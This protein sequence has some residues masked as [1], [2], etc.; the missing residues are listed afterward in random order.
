MKYKLAI[1]Y[2]IYPGI[3]KVPAIFS[4]NKLRM[5][6]LA[7]RSFVRA[8]DGID[9]KIWVLLDNCDDTYNQLFKKYLSGMNYELINLPPSGNAGTFGMQMNILLHQDFSEY[10]FFAED[11]YFYLDNSLLPSLEILEK[12]FADFVT[13]YNHPE[14]ESSNLHDYRV[15]IFDVDGRKWRTAASTTMT[16]MTTR[17][18]LEGSWDKFL[19]YTKLNYDASMW[20]AITKFNIRNPIKIVKDSIKSIEQLKIYL[21]CFYFFPFAYLGRK[22]KLASPL[23]SLATHLDNNGL[24]KEVNW[25]AEFEKFQ[26]GL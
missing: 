9:A 6:E 25:Q 10:I 8:L 15:E 22:Q 4:D 26:N 11:D 19:S 21:K 17:K 16:F 7:L 3:S 24:P 2:R 5:S 23:Q 1:C 14:L 13:P 20:M 12:C 18:A